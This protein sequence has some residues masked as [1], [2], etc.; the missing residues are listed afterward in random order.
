MRS[1]LLVYQPSPANYT[2]IRSL[3]EFSTKNSTVSGYLA[4]I[5]GARQ[6][7]AMTRTAKRT[8]FIDMLE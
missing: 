3:Q 6:G 4:G 7:T 2:L 8:S 1:G 5:R